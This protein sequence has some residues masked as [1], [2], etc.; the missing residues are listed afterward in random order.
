MD[1]PVKRLSPNAYVKWTL[2]SRSLG[3]RGFGE[4]VQEGQ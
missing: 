2:K 4:N 3:R 1:G